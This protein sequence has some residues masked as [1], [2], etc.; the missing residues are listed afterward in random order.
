MHMRNSSNRILN[1]YNQNLQPNTNHDFSYF[2]H[3]LTESKS[4]NFFRHK[5]QK[6]LKC[7]I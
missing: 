1:Q 5:S 3:V 6:A 4:L 2:T 7:D